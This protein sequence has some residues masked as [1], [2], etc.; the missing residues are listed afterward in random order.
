MKTY[1]RTWY[2]NNLINQ[3]KAILNFVKQF[4][5]KCFPSSLNSYERMKKKADDERHF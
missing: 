4:R 3:I 2:V 1:N 5:L